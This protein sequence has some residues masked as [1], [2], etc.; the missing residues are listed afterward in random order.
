MPTARGVLLIGILGLMRSS[1]SAVTVAVTMLAL[2]GCAG[3]SSGSASPPP[4]GASASVVLDTYLRAL[5]AGD[6]AAAHAVAAPTFSKG[7]GEL[8][9]DVK[10]SAFSLSGDP[11]TP[12]SNEVVYSSV[13]TTEGSSDGTIAPG[14][15]VWFYDLKR[16][17]GEWKLVGGGSGP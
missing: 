17:G 11:A 8:C 7:N 1:A 10:V 4:A 6:C 13:L 12:G 5:T 9:G 3:P 2:T 15:T 14:E 16:Q